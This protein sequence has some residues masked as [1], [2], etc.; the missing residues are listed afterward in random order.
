MRVDVFVC[1]Y[2]WAAADWDDDE[3]DNDDYGSVLDARTC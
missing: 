1:A 2:V 3:Y